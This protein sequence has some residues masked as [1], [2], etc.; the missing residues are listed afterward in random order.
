MIEWWG[1]AEV[2][3]AFFKATEV[4]GPGKIAD[5]GGVNS[6]LQF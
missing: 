1:E 6:M 3:M 4:S 2:E 5:S